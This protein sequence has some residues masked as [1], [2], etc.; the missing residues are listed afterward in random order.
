MNIFMPA[1]KYIYVRKKNKVTHVIN[2]IVFLL[3][4]ESKKKLNNEYVIF[5][6]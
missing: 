4:S 6:T 2:R 5:S 3:R 1:Q